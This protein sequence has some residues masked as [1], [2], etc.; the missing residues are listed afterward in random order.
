MSE[1]KVIDGVVHIPYKSI[2]EYAYKVA[3]N[4]EGYRTFE[5]LEDQHQ[6]EVNRVY[7]RYTEKEYEEVPQEEIDKY[8]AFIQELKDEWE[9]D[10]YE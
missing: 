10:D 2:L 1:I 6:Q 8:D 9:N 7:G 4:C 3:E 5:E